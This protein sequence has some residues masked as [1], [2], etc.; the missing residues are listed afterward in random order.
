MIKID[1]DNF[2]LEDIKN[3]MHPSIFYDD[4]NYDLFILRLPILEQEK[5]DFY[6]NAFI[7]TDEG[8]Y[9]FDKKN[10]KFIE[11]K[12]INSFY[13]FL[14]KSINTTMKIVS[15]Y[16]SNVTDLEEVV[17]QGKTQKSF[18]AMWFSYKND[19]IRISKVL[20][21]SIETVEEMIYTYKKEE[22]YLK[23]NFEDIH[24]HM[25][26]AYRSVVLSLEKLDALFRFY[27]TQ[28]N[29]QMNKI[30][31]ILTLL[32]GIFLPLNF[33]VGFFGMNTTSLPFTKEI[34]G[35]LSV[36]VI[37]VLTGLIATTLTIIM[38]RK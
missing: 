37:L 24:E 16:F 8:Y 29:E 1:I 27:Q 13:K 10:D 32:S 20:Y 2:H 9:H 7:I 38:R 15:D 28:I 12:D 3:H 17:Y 30:V 5:L 34:G 11:L 26:R 25:Q 21:K 14:N 31:Y 23:R 22:D 35:T 6:S 19:L 33:I 36:T 4:I 18:N